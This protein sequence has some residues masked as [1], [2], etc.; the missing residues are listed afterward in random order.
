MIDGKRLYLMAKD[1]D[2]RCLFARPNPKDP[3]YWLVP[4]QCPHYKKSPCVF[5]GE[6]CGLTKDKGL[7]KWIEKKD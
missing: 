2:D 1:S 7:L 6:Y 4:H 3:K 5:S